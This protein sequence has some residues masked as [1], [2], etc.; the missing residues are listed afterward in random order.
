MDMNYWDIYSQR[1][2]ATIC[3]HCCP[4][5]ANRYV[6]RPSE[7]VCEVL[8]LGAFN[9]ILYSFSYLYVDSCSIA[10]QWVVEGTYLS[11][12]GKAFFVGTKQNKVEHYIFCIMSH[13]HTHTLTH[14]H[15]H[16]HTH[17]SK[18]SIYNSL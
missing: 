18:M 7:A 6:I 8:C 1:V 14:T 16:T 17:T 3:H 15:T 12:R 13:T 5:G 2:H 10:M 4:S 11:F 9:S